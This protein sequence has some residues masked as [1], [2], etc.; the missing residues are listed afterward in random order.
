MQYFISPYISFL[1]LKIFPRVTHSAFRK[2]VTGKR[3]DLF[4]R[5]LPHKEY[6]WNPESGGF[7]SDLYVQCVTFAMC[8]SPKFV[9]YSKNE[10]ICLKQYLSENIYFSSFKPL[11]FIYVRCE[12]TYMTLWYMHQGTCT[13]NLVLRENGSE[14]N[15]PHITSNF[16]QNTARTVANI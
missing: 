2:A 4:I 7:L 9:H 12:K 10:L 5:N 6:K 3:N 1:C 16:L 11:I 8:A 15:V 14:V 13:S